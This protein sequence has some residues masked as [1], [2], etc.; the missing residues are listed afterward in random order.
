MPR[1]GLLRRLSWVPSV[2]RVETQ[3][4]Y[5]EDKEVES[6]TRYYYRLKMV[7]LDGSFE[8]SEVVAISSK[9]TIVSQIYPNPF[10]KIGPLKIHISR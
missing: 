1:S 9:T 2:N 4:Y 8:Y 6:N 5:W 10:I 7:D 3:N